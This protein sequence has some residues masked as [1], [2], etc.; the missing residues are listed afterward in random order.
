MTHNGLRKIKNGSIKFFGRVYKPRD[1][2]RGE[3]DGQT[4]L[5]IAYEPL[6][7]TKTLAMWGSKEL[8]KAKVFVELENRLRGEK[9]IMRDGVIKWYIWKEKESINPMS[10]DNR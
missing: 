3:L 8:Y 10:H 4:W 7:Q 6:E 5:F 1:E 9:N 2:Y